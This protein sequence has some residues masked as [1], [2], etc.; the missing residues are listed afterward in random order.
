MISRRAFTKA[1]GLTLFGVGLGGVPS[2]IARAANQTKIVS[3]YKKNKILV[4]IF[5]RSPYFVY[6]C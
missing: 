5:Q 2:F 4:C 6:G 1:G 3:P